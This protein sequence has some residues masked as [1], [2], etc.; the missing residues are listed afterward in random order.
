M[1]TFFSSVNIPL[2]S[3]AVKIAGFNYGD[4]L[5]NKLGVA[6]TE[7][8]VKVT[9]AWVSHTQ[10]AQLPQIK[11]KLAVAFKGNFHVQ[12]LLSLGQTYA[13]Q[14][15]DSYISVCAT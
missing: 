12:Q 5:S 7:E 9:V 6:S 14:L 1:S 8:G 4:D 11:P 13:M 15:T 2:V 10:V 3:A